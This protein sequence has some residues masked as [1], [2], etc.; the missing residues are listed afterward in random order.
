MGWPVPSKPDRHYAPLI[1][2]LQAGAVVL[3]FLASLTAIVLRHERKGEPRFLCPATGRTSIN[4]PPSSAPPAPPSPTPPPGV[5]FFPFSGPSKPFL[6][7][8]LS[9]T[10]GVSVSFFGD[11]VQSEAVCITPLADPERYPPFTGQ[12]SPPVQ[13]LVDESKLPQMQ[14][15]AITIPYEDPGDSEKEANL[16]VLVYDED[17]HVWKSASEAVSVDAARNLVTVPVNRF[18]VFTV[19]TE[20]VLEQLDNAAFGLCRAGT[21]FTRPMLDI[22]VAIDSSSSMKEND[23]DDLRKAAARTLIRGLQ[24]NDALA[25]IDFDT[26]VRVL[27]PLTM[28]RQAASAAIDQIDSVGGTDLNAGVSQGLSLLEGSASRKRVLVVLTDGQA[29]YDPALSARAAQA[30]IQIF[31]I[32]LG[33]AQ[34]PLCSR[35]WH[36]PRRGSSS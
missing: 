6:P 5:A 21:L 10:S 20:A 14:S 17:A 13:V 3:L 2:R 12:L 32:G 18:S 28:D 26:Q 16:M 23:P 30:S 1:I 9:S 35:T 19:A 27:A 25:I 7:T 29:P 33:D 11:P 36:L 31:P 15:A 34:T 8:K 22:A 4:Q 24:A